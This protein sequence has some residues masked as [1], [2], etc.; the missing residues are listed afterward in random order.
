[1]ILLSPSQVEIYCNGLVEVARDPPGANWCGNDEAHDLVEHFVEARWRPGKSGDPQ[2]DE[3]LIVN[4]AL[5]LRNK[6]ERWFDPVVWAQGGDE[7][8]AREE[9]LDVIES[10]RHAALENLS[11]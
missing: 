1:M 6:L 2:Q 9:I 5:D 11:H 4:I 8:A 3:T 7:H 10:L